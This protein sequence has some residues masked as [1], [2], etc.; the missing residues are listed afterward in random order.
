MSNNP[1]SKLDIAFN[2]YYAVHLATQKKNNYRYTKT[3]DPRINLDRAIEK[4]QKQNSRREK[5]NEEKVALEKSCEDMKPYLMAYCDAAD[6]ADARLN[7]LLS[8]KDLP[9]NILLLYK[10]TDECSPKKTTVECL[11]FSKDLR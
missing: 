4:L 7:L 5:T 10:E 6:A 2:E 1:R 11:L 3:N 9:S 8:Y